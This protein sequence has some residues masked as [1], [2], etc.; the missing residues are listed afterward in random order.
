MGGGFGCGFSS[1]GWGCGGGE[2]V[3][4]K[5]CNWNVEEKRCHTLVIKNTCPFPVHNPGPPNGY[6]TGCTHNNKLADLGTEGGDEMNFSLD[7][8]V[9]NKAYL[10]DGMQYDWNDFSDVLNDANFRDLLGT[11][12]CA[13]NS[14]GWF[15]QGVRRNSNQNQDCQ[16]KISPNGAFKERCAQNN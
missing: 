6:K 11:F 4:G 5:Y 13:S 7:E 15:C 1:T 10:E 2:Q 16:W 3:D 8:S 14:N 12:L 9:E